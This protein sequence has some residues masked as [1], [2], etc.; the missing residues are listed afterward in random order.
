MSLWRMS[1]YGAILVAVVALLR[2]VLVDKLPKKTF[3]CLWAVALARLL[4]PFDLPS[5]ASVYNAAPAAVRRAPALTGTVIHTPAPPAASVDIWPVVWLAGAAACALFFLWTWLRCRRE[6]REALP[7]E[8]GFPVQWLALQGLRRA[9]ALRQSD[10]VSAPLTYGLFR[11]VIL[12]P[13]TMDWENTDQV[14]YVLSH[15]LVHIKRLD[16]LWKLLLT[17]A[18]CLH[19]FN[20]LVWIMYIL[21]NRDLELSCDES[22]V[23]SYGEGARQGYALALLGMEERRSTLRP[24]CN[25]FSKNAIEERIRSIMKMKKTTAAAVAVALVL[26]AGVTV[27][28]ATSA[29]RAPI[30]ATPAPVKGSATVEDVTSGAWYK[31]VVAEAAQT[32][33]NV[34]KAKA[35]DWE[36][37]WEDGKPDPQT[38]HYYTKAQYDL[39]A[40]L[41]T[42]GYEKQSIAQFNR[43]LRAKFNSDD[44]SGNKLYQSFWELYG[45]LPV[46]DPLAPFLYYTIQASDEEY[47]ARLDEAYTGKRHDPEF[48]AKAERSEHADVFGDR[49]QVGSAEIDYTFTYRILD[50][51]G[52]TVAARDK[53][54]TDLTSGMQ[55]FLDG[56]KLDELDDEEAL[57]K[58]AQAELERLGKA[59][60][61]KS[62]EFTG[63]TVEWASAYFYRE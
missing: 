40:A 10:R 62:V 59:L 26:V 30:P 4:L 49:V 35:E 42:A 45:E 38:G 18:L 7:V 47:G 39:V 12:M 55:K 31:K 61:T 34:A 8:E 19:W 32:A 37:D 9:V 53:F 29:S 50:Q 56:K 11:P 58:A 41:K 14:R 36:P 60:T 17:A 24:L 20:P 44:D 28:F 63:G 3:L 46:D 48:H 5:R 21:A 1:L 23:R 16:G 51:D 13:K 25:N 43:E 52:L 57:Q 54:L 27:A 22:V 15:E 6:F 2:A 33:A